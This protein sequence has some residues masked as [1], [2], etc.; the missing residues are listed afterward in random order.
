MID[1]KKQSEKE[2][3]KRMCMYIVRVEELQENILKVLKG[4][5]GGNARKALNDYSILKLEIR[6]EH[7]YLDT[8]KN[9][10]H[11]ISNTHATYQ[12]GIFETNAKGFSSKIGSPI[13]SELSDTVSDVLSELTGS[14][15]KDEWLEIAAGLK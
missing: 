13:S 9:D 2:I 11:D 5:D 3:A 6:E 7:K 15:S 4:E 1:F 10:I 8:N 14:Y 12:G